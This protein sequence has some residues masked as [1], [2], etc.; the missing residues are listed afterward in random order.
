MRSG[1]TG[2]VV[3]ES[4]F[5]NVLLVPQAATVELQDKVFVFLLGKGNSVK[6]QVITVTGKSGNNY[7][8][9]SGLKQGDTIVTAGTEKLPDGMVIRPVRNAPV[10]GEARP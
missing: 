3:V 10:S 5:H 4:L 2:K 1:N 7:I 6:K 9:G 8:V